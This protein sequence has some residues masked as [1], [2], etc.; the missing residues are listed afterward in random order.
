[1][2]EN[3]AL[4]LG[5]FEGGTATVELAGGQRLLIERT[6]DG[7]V[8]TLVAEGGE[9]ALT[10]RVQPNGPVLCFKSGLRLEAAGQLELAGEK[11]LIEG[12][13]GVA[14][15]SGGN[16]RIDVKGDITLAARI[17]NITARLGNVNVKANDDVRMSA[18]RIR[19]NC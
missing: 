1:M 11:V 15:R 8:L 2:Y 18:E 14:I 16:A 9:V 10:V 3:A 17:Q 6:G 19:L 7:D 13:D 12:R 4:D 5:E